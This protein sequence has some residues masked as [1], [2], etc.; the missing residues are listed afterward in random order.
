VRGYAS[1][2][3][4]GT[5]ALAAGAELRVPLILVGRAL[6]H[7]PLGADMVSLA[8]FADAGDAWNAG[9]RGRLT[10]L[11]S[12]GAELVADV[13]FNYDA[14]LRARLGV[15]QPREDVAPRWY[16]ALGSSF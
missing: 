14:P 10:R 12:A 3:R 8:L 6:G 13:T 4:R 16:V 9:E 5:R 11:A 15:A 1:G 2:A 7:L